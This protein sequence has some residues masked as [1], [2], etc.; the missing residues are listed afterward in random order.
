MTDSIKIQHVFTFDRDGHHF[1][2]ALNL[3]IGEYNKLSESD[4]EQLKEERYQNWLTVLNT[5]QPEPSKEQQLLDVEAQIASLD[6][7]KTML[8][9]NWVELTAQ[10][11]ALELPV[12][13]VI[14]SLK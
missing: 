14:K 7:Q 5:P 1:C 8:L 2:D 10:V 12:K 4:I 9:N 13:E 3:P 6:E 11:E